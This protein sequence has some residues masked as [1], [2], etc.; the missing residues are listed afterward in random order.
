ME[1]CIDA[2]QPGGGF[3]LMPSSSL[4]TDVAPVNIEAMYEHA[5]RYGGDF[6]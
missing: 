2:G 3:V 5:Q 1:R 6:F 4:G